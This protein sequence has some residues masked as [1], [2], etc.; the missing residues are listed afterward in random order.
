MTKPTVMQAKA[1]ELIREGNTPR[2]AMLKAGYS[3]ATASHPSDNLL[4]TPGTQS[5]IEQYKAEYTKAG[6]TPEYMVKKTKEWL[7]AKKVKTSLTEP[8]QIVEDYQTQLKAAEFVRKDF[9]LAEPLQSQQQT[10]NVQIN[11]TRGDNNG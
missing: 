7:E 6:I 5:I 4:R 8:D 10:T 2:Q 9:G 3:V 11:L 1:M